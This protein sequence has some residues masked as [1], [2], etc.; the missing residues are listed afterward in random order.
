MALVDAFLQDS[1]EFNVWIAIR[2]DSASG[3]GT[4][5]DPFNGATLSGPPIPVT[6]AISGSSPFDREAVVNTGS[7]RHGFESGD[8][9][10]ISGVTGDDAELWNGTFGIYGVSDFSFKYY[11]KKA[12][13]PF[14]PGNPQCVQLNVLLDKVMRNIP[15]NIRIHLGPGVFQ[16]RGF[17]AGDDR[18]WQPKTGQKIVGAGF[19]VTL[20]QLLNGVSPAH[21]HIFPPFIRY[22]NWTMRPKM[23]W[24]RLVPQMNPVIP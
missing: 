24:C 17:A 12:P 10:T 3:T 16:T 8:L 15:A 19:D 11:M 22:K 4:A 5:Q 6:L 14:P 18:G 2:T 7:V 20:L 23:H 13:E 9:V 21:S 1:F